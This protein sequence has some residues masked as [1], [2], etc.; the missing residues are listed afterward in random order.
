MMDWC[1]SPA[2]AYPPAQDWAWKYAEE[3]WD[4]RQEYLRVIYAESSCWYCQLGIGSGRISL[5]DVPEP[6]NWKST[7]CD[8]HLE[9]IAPAHED[10]EDVVCIICK[11]KYKYRPWNKLIG[12]QDKRCYCLQC[13]SGFRSRHLDD[14][15]LVEGKPDELDRLTNLEKSY[16]VRDY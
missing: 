12:R 6:P 2:R 1:N 11:K 15:R 9:S 13:V 8:G 4:T 3:A 5:Q 14:D 16:G 7:L 10:G